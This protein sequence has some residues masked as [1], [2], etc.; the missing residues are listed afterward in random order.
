MK[1][2]KKTLILKHKTLKKSL[3]FK[4]TL[5]DTE[6]ETNMSVRDRK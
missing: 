4:N 2:K 6:T 3:K 5:E 1:T